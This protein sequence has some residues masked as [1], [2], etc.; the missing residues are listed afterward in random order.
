M[1]W[2]A[3]LVE[4]ELGVS[5]L[6]PPADVATHAPDR[7]GVAASGAPTMRDTEKRA[8]LLALESKAQQIITVASRLPS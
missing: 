2:A 6:A 8:I 5:E 3:I 4:G 7:A 1:G